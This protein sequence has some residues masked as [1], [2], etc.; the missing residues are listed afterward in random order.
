VLGFERAAPAET[1]R[2][3]YHPAILR[4][5]YVYGKL[6]RI[7][8]SRRLEREAQRNVELSWLMKR[9]VPDFKTIADFRRDNGAAIRAAC[10]QFVM[11]CRGLGLF[12]QAM[13]AIDGSKSKAVNNRDRNYTTQPCPIPLGVEGRG[14]RCP[15]WLARCAARAWRC[16]ANPE[17]R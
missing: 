3:G 17:C 4:K 7:R 13:A 6:N 15:A 8:S 14:H 5:L 1:G 2:P 16:A 11:L 10:L 12:A 9:L